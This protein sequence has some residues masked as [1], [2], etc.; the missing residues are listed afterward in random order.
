MTIAIIVIEIRVELQA[1]SFVYTPVFV[2]Y[3]YCM[4]KFDFPKIQRDAFTVASAFAQSDEKS[5]WLSRTPYERLEAVELM[6][7]IIYG[8]DSS[9]IRLQRV[10]E[11]TQRS[12]G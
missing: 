5:Y 10:L 6:R 1:G 3:S 8:Y 2:W 4:D 7:Q 11:V 9:A 12:S